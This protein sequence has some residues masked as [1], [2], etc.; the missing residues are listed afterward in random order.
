MALISKKSEPGKEAV[1]SDL[2]KLENKKRKEIE[3][4]LARE[5]K[6]SVMPQQLR[7]AHVH[8]SNAQTTGV[9]IMVGGL[10]FLLGASVGAYYLFFSTPAA[11]A[12][13]IV[14][15]VATAPVAPTSTNK[16]INLTTVKIEA[17]KDVYLRM[18]ADFDRVYNFQTLNDFIK[19]NGS[20]NRISKWQRDS[21]SATTTNAQEILATN[22]I[23]SSTKLSNI[24]DV[25]ESNINDAISLSIT[26]K[27][28]SQTGEVVLVKENDVWK[29]DSENWQIKNN[30]L[31]LKLAAATTTSQV[32]AFQPGVDTDNDGLTDKEERVFRTD[33]FVRDTDSDGHA[34]GA[35]VASGFDPAL[36]GGAKL[37]NNSGL[38]LYKDP[39]YGYSLLS[40]KDWPARVL[41]GADAVIFYAP[42]NQFIQVSVQPNIN[43]QLIADWFNNQFVS[44]SSDGGNLA[45]KNKVVTANWEGIKSADGMNF[46]LTDKDNKN[47]FTISYNAGVNNIL[48]YSH[49]FEA[50]ATSFVLP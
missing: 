13:R 27:D 26:T 44:T 18:M 40:P 10:L 17:P 21:A 24:K 8:I 42:D 4:S 5:L 46:Y 35:E 38:T 50:M 1:V 47:I 23:A 36:S 20:F 29:I 2:V 3:D 25:L 33:Q 14:K 16:T 28:N 39:A 32:V 37:A 6:V 45:A 22:I 41:A 43:H 34:D 12:P 9:F 11:P 31:E 30:G 15:P 49:L 7:E 48:D 19:K